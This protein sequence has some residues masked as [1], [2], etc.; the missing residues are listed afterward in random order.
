[1]LEREG[2]PLETDRDLDPLIQA[3]GDK[4]FVFL[5][6]A[7][8]G[9]HEYYTWRAR[10]S[11]RLI[12]EKGFHFIA[13]EG[14]WPDCYQINKYIKGFHDAATSPVDIVK[15]FKVRPCVWW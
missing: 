4:R 7:S 14:D 13:M 15:H 1:M 6:E 5:G 12:E 10:L 3:I 9:T 8:H 2:L 11:K